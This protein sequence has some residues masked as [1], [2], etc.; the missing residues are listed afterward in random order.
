VGVVL[1]R[2]VSESEENCGDDE[3]D[4]SSEQDVFWR[5]DMREGTGKRDRKCQN[6]YRDPK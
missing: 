5:D 3:K 2:R 6:A 4:L 1:G